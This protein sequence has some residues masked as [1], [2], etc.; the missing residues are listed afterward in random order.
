MLESHQAHGC[1]VSMKGLAELTPRHLVAVL[2]SGRVVS[3]ASTDGPTKLL[4]HVQSLLEL[5]T[6]QKPKLELCDAK[7][8][9]CLKWIRCLGEHQRVHHYK[10]SV[11]RLQHL[12]VVQLTASSV[13]EVL[14][15]HPHELVL[16]D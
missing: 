2:K 3:P 4:G 16:H 14:H 5:D 8:V 9:I 11:G 10:V 12:L 7:P 6:V 15:Q 13:H 1:V